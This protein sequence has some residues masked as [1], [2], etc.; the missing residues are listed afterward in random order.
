MF[1]KSFVALAAV[2]LVSWLLF[3]GTRDTATAKGP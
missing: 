1:T 3:V 2:L